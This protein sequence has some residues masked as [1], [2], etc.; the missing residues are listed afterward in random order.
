MDAVDG[1]AWV[2][3]PKVAGSGPAG[4]TTN[5]SSVPRLDGRSERPFWSVVGNSWA[6]V[7]S[8]LPRV[9]NSASWS[10]NCRLNDL[11]VTNDV[12]APLVDRKLVAARSAA[13][14]GPRLLP[15]DMDTWNIADWAK[16]EAAG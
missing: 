6:I 11:V 15:F 5:L 10:I 7:G 3:D 14:R 1:R 4:R 16:S 13:L 2:A 9:G 12:K 8:A